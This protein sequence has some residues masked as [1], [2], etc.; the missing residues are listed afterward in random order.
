MITSILAALL[1]GLALG[2][3]VMSARA[4]LRWLGL[5][6]LAILVG[7]NLLGVYVENKAPA[8]G[9]EKLAELAAGAPVQIVTDPLTRQRAELPLRWANVRDRVT[10]AVPRAGDLY[11]HN[12]ARSAQASLLIAEKDL[13]SFLPQP[14]WE[15]VARFEP[16]P[17]LLARALEATRIDEAL[18]E[19]LWRKLRYRHEPT[20]LY[21]IG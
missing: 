1:A 20:V 2:L 15:Q 3:L 9:E 18:P 4:P 7:T 5:S 19:G 14:G 12:P 17:S 11:F 13:P 6:L 8:W 10:G 16:E 21:R